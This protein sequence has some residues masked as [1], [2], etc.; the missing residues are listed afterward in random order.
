MKAFWRYIRKHHEEYGV[1]LF[2]VPML[3]VVF[4][5]AGICYG[6]AWLFQ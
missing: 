5:V 6:V 4:A 2:L 1:A 3:L